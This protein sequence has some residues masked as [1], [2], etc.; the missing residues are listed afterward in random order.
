M[1]NDLVEKRKVLYV[2]HSLPGTTRY[3]YEVIKYTGQ[4]TRPSNNSVFSKYDFKCLQKGHVYLDQE[5]QNKA[6]KKCKQAPIN[7]GY[8]NSVDDYVPDNDRLVAI[9][10]SDNKFF[11]DKFIQAKNKWLRFESFDNRIKVT[12]WLD[13]KFPENA[14]V[15]KEPMPDVKVIIDEKKSAY[16]KFLDELTSLIKKEIE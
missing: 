13:I 11:F 12:H 8:W 16:R 2:R 3:C 14:K 5:I 6:C 9:R 10:T 4:G 1:K 7:V 15:D